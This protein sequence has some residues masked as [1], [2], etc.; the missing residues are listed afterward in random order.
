MRFRVLVLGGYGTFGERISTELAA[1]PQLHVVIAGRNAIR[2]AQLA[3]QLATRIPRSAVVGIGCDIDGADFATQLTQ[4][5]VSAVINTCGPFQ[6]RDYRVAEACIGAGVHYVDLADARGYVCGFH[7]LDKL[8]KRHNVLAVT[9]ASTVPALSSAV[10]DAY[11]AD[12]K[13]LLTIDYGISPGNR[14]PRGVATV[15]AILSYCGKRF[16]QWRAGR[17]TDA[18]GWQGLVRRRYP[19][20]MGSRWLSYCDIPDLALFPHRYPGVRDVVFRAGVELTLLHLGTWLLSALTRVGMVKNWSAHAHALKRISEWFQSF[21]SDVGGM[22]V[23]LTGIDA[24]D[25]TIRR[26]WY[27]LAYDGDGPQVPCTPAV[28]LIKKLARGQ[29]PQRGAMPCMGLLSLDELV[30]AMKHFAIRS[31]LTTQEL[32]RY[33]ENS[34]GIRDIGR[35]G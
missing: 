16:A 25:K 15:S 12:F 32:V 14:T 27:L 18:I 6:G 1:D 17:W 5:N 4:L 30:R 8:A 7:A 19:K 33:P 10:I 28:I 35:L 24:R 20:P 2:A 3:Q 21:G 22:H 23:T 11:S 29:L 26:T 13:Q 9:G 31:A 34:P